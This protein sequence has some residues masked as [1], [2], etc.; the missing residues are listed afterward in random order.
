MLMF[1][2]LFR[3]RLWIPAF[4]GDGNM[5]Y[6]IWLLLSANFFDCSWVIKV[7]VLFRLFSDPS[8]AI[9]P[10]SDEFKRVNPGVSKSKSS[11]THGIVF[12]RILESKMD[13]SESDGEQVLLLFE[14]LLIYFVLS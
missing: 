1:L 3:I 14:N 13:E 7:F 9:D 12:M 10:N 6:F 11:L 2:L 8:L 4:Q 5:L